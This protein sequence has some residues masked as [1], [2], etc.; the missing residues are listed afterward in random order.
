M[1]AQMTA[2]TEA[3]REQNRHPS[4]RF[5]AGAAVESDCRLGGLGR[6]A[7][8]QAAIIT[9]SD[10]DPCNPGRSQATSSELLTAHATMTRGCSGL[11]STTEKARAISACVRASIDDR[12]GLSPADYDTVMAGVMPD[13][14]EATRLL[15]ARHQ[16]AAEHLYDVRAGTALPGDHPLDAQT[17]EDYRA[18]LGI[19]EPDDAD[20][21]GGANELALAWSYRLDREALDLARHTSRA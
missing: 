6:D 10:F 5:G 1:S 11:A 19:H 21:V 8:R 14:P 16:G 17:I 18:H 15:A 13:D 2:A 9:M 4:G 7:V 20:P 12:G 3:A